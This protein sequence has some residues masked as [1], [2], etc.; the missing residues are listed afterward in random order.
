[1]KALVKTTM[2][3]YQLYTVRDKDINGYTL[4]NQ[5]GGQWYVYNYR[6]LLEVG[7]NITLEEIENDFPEYFL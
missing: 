7:H 3:G 2:E 4:Y 5:N 1:M 6:V